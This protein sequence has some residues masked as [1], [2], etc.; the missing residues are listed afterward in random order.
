MCNTNANMIEKMSLH[1]RTMYVKRGGHLAVFNAEQV[2]EMQE[3]ALDTKDNRLYD[4]LN[5]FWLQS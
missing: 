4:V 5:T 1:E 3:Y 2:K